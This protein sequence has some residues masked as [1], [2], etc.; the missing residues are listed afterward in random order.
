MSTYKYGYLMTEDKIIALK[1]VGLEH[2]QVSLDG[3][4]SK[5]HDY[6]RNVNIKK[7]LNSNLKFEFKRNW[8]LSLF[9]SS[10]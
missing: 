8:I 6:M 3:V 2:L 1:E 10:K 9:Y 5:T 7:D 4:D